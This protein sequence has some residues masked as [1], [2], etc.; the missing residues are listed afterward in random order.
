[1]SARRCS[2][3]HRLVPGNAP[4]FAD[5]GSPLEG[6]YVTCACGSTMFFPSKGTLGKDQESAV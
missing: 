5:G 6:Y 2:C 1:M 4:H 3:G